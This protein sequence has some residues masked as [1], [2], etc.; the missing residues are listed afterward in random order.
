MAANRMMGS[1]ASD[2]WP[3]LPRLRGLP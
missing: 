3:V 1:K 2:H